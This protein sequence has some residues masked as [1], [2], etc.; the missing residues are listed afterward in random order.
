MT[1]KKGA[2]KMAKYTELAQDIL[3]HVGG[4]ENVSSVNT[5]W[6]AYGST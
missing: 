2:I 6:L 3:A 4:K 1:N 5:V